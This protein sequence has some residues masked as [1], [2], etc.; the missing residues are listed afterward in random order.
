MNQAGST[1][2]I[3][4]WPRTGLD[5]KSHNEGYVLNVVHC[6]PIDHLQVLLTANTPLSFVTNS[7]LQFS[8]QFVTVLCFWIVDEEVI[9]LIFQVQE[10]G[11]VS[12]IFAEESRVTSNISAG[13]LLTQGWQ[14]EKEKLSKTC[15]HRNLWLTE[16]TTCCKTR[17]SKKAIK[18]LCEIPVLI[19]PIVSTQST[20]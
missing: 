20:A 18:V 5:L 14:Q 10:S 3:R 2:R 17:H 16:K 11:A 6:I 9:Q 13:N 7:V 15:H 1:Y 12:F 4:I 19:F 8:N